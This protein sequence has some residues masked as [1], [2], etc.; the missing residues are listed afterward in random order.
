MNV[1]LRLPI[2]SDA[3]PLER[4]FDLREYVNFLWRQWV[5]IAAITALAVVVAFV[6]L[7]RATPLYTSTA[8]ILLDPRREKAMGADAILADFELGDASAVESQLAIIKSD[9]LLRRVV[10]KQRLVPSAPAAPEQEEQPQQQQPQ[11]RPWYSRFWGGSKRAAPSEAE[12]VQG[13]VGG[14]RSAL[15]VNRGGQAYVLNVSVTSPD[16][17]KAAELSNAIADAYVLDKLDA[18]FEAAK[19]ASAWL[20]DRLV[21]L[22]QQ[23]RDSE[24]AVATFRTEHGMVRTGTANVTLSEQQMGELNSKLIAARADAAEKK[25]RVDFLAEVAAGKKTIDSLPDSLQSSPQATG[26]MNLRQRLAEVSQREADLMTRYS[27]RHPAVANVQAQKRDIEASIKAET[28]RMIETVNGEYK[29][30]KAREEATE[31]AVREAAGGGDLDG[32]AAIRLREL[33]RT[34]AVNKSLF[35]DFLQ[36]AKI[37]EEQSTFQARDARVITPAQP[38]GHPSYPRTNLILGIALFMGIALGIGGATAIEMLHAG[39]TTP[40]QVEDLL[41]IPVLASVRQMDRSQLMKDG[42]PIPIPLYQV[43]HP[44]SPFSEAIRTLRSGIQM[45]DVDRPPKVIQVT[46]SRPG[47]GKTTVALS[48]A[49]SAGYSNLRVAL[50]DGDLRHPSCSRFFRLEKEKGLVDV[51]TG[52]APVNEV[53]RHHK[54][55]N[56]WILPAGSKSLNPPDVLSSE[57]M[58]TLIAQ[59]K[60]KFDYVVVDTPPVGPVVDAVI[61]ARLVDK[62]IFVVQWGSTPRELVE[63]CMHQLSAQKRVGG[64]VLNFLNR[65]RAK[66][67][68]PEYYY[69]GRYYEKYYSEE[70]HAVQV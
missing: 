59:M 38:P 14:L 41:G 25:T 19:R 39:F 47:E 61:V 43:H 34:A 24:E 16:P 18:R 13:V 51:L 52:A 21:E 33:E 20:S 23:L 62:S 37:T 26:M 9:V 66:K 48:L 7:A 45:S 15:T 10:I 57:R 56:L 1:G 40:R 67:Y 11:Q 28:Q 3:E 29:L 36:R 69:G 65:D 49:I 6:Y 54:E 44:L 8:Q 22:R 42:R 12:L 35:E 2:Q 64:A 17:A 70:R 5:F 55:L 4:R 63:T 32:Q 58:K 68:G 27:S 46:S 31:R 30:A 60:E 53:M 50:I